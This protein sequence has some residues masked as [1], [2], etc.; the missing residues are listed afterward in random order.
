MFFRFYPEARN[1]K[2]RNL[3]DKIRLFDS[4]PTNADGI[5]NLMFTS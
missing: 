1:N 3:K 4:V 2:F 5:E